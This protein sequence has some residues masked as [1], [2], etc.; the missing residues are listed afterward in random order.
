[1]AEKFIRENRVA[2]SAVS[3][4]DIFQEPGLVKNSLAMIAANAFGTDLLDRV[5]TAAYEFQ[6]ARATAFLS[7]RKSAAE[8]AGLVRRYHAFLLEFGGKYL[9]TDVKIPD[10]RMV[11]ILETF[12]LVF[13]RGP[14]LA[15][16][17]QSPDKA[18]TE[19]LAARLYQR[20]QEVRHEP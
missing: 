20:L 19:M 1:M 18:R 16:V 9:K 11:E 13:S 14:F 2:Q 4:E 8:A 17:R 6:G 12:E 10:A 3:E 5:F 7:R 15:G